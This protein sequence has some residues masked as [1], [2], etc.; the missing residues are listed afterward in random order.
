MVN[1]EHPIL[2]QSRTVRLFVDDDCFLFF[3]FLGMVT[4]RAVSA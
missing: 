3:F 1:R 2:G 4:G